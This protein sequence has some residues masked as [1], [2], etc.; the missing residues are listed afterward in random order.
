MIAIDVLCAGAVLAALAAR[1]LGPRP[2]RMADDRAR[3]RATVQR[4]TTR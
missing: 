1:L 3:F 4:E 2:D